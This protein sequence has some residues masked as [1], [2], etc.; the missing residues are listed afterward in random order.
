MGKKTKVALLVLV[1]VFL[2]AQFFQPA[3]GNP[4]SEPAAAFEV[5]ANPPPEARAIIRRA[6]Q[7]CHS[8]RTEWPW[9]SRVSPSSWL[10]ANDVTEA[11]E[12]LNL[13]EWGRMSPESRL[14]ALGDICREVNAGDMPLWQYRIMHPS[15]K[16]TAA[17]SDTLCLLSVTPR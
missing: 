1:A 17:D 4:P 15:A 11:R 14:K 7:D 9:Y 6:C 3:R 2:V 13:S 10:V 8:N 12:H 5:V 16:L